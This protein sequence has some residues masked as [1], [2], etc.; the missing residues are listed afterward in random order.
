MLPADERHAILRQEVRLN[1]KQ[2]DGSAFR[3]SFIS[4]LSLRLSLDADSVT[5]IVEERKFVVVE[6]GWR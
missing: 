5:G 3:A 2:I 4:G 1:L 6:T